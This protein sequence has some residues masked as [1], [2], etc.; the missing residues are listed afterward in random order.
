MQP[1]GSDALKL[2]VTEKYIRQL[3]RVRGPD[4]RVLLPADLNNLDDLLESIGLKTG[5]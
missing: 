3:S 1:G 4:T 5:T 2:R